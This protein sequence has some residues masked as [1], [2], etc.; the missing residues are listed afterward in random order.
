MTYICILFCEILGVSPKTIGNPKHGAS[1]G[2]GG[3][4]GAGWSMRFFIYNWGGG[5]LL[6]DIVTSELVIIKS[7]LWYRIVFWKF[8]IKIYHLIWRD[9]TNNAI[10]R[11]WSW[12]TSGSMFKSYVTSG[13]TSSQVTLAAFTGDRTLHTPK[14]PARKIKHKNH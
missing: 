11:S 13:L 10:V 3:G 5:V 8:L 2:V 12:Y 6:Y 9:F 1:G 4:G 14:C 7:Y